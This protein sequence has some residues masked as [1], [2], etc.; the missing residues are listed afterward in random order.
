MAEPSATPTRRATFS[1]LLSSYAYTPQPSRTA[2]SLPSTPVPKRKRPVSKNS[3]PARTVSRRN[4]K[5][6]S[7]ALLVV[8]TSER[9]VSPAKVPQ[10][11]RNRS[12]SVT[13]NHQV[14]T[15][16]GDTSIYFTTS[17]TQAGGGASTSDRRHNSSRKLPDAS[18][19]LVKATDATPLLS[20]EDLSVEVSEGLNGRCKP[21]P[22]RVV[23]AP[24][25]K[26]YLSSISHKV[27]ST[28]SADSSRPRKHRKVVPPTQFATLNSKSRAVSLDTSTVCTTNTSTLTTSKYFCE[29]AR[30]GKSWVPSYFPS[31]N[32]FTHNYMPTFPSYHQDLFNDLIG[33]IA[34]AKPIL[35][36]DAV[37]DN[38]WQLLIA[39]KLLNVT[40]GQ[41]AIPVFWKLMYRWPT[42]LDMI[43]DTPH[44]K[45][46]IT[47][48]VNILR[49]LGLY[50][51]RT[52]WLK[53]MSQHYVDDPPTDICRPSNCRLETPARFKIKITA[54][55]YTNS[56]KRPSCSSPSSRRLRK[57]T[58]PYPPTP[59][60][61][62]P[63][64][65]RYALDSYRIFCT[66]GGEWKEVMPEDKELIRYLRWK[67]AYEERKI[68]YPDGV[69]VVKDVDIPYLLILVDELMEELEPDEFW[70]A[71]DFISG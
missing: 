13:S 66:A 16:A 9:H 4:S 69:G 53:A 20:R 21:E 63:G 49:P 71:T 67:W 28:L 54:P 52:A 8:S 17:R 40:T 7:Q 30:P 15:A 55:T 31:E 29:V 25:Q 36:Q 12:K 6:S 59:I 46:D 1:Q 32:L 47:E 18:E 62:Y 58:I 45:A 42:P 56:R 43:N 35:I 26:C 23:D 22:P 5:N 61:H 27:C 70:G 19:I 38:L 2:L 34:N 64:I 39:V 37:S 41:Y 14:P 10:S 50:N 65:G 24:H 48:L 57:A 51:K 11:K 33:F 60:S 44:D 3:T 68:W